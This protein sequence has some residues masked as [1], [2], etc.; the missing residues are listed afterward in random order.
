MSEGKNNQTDIW[1]GLVII[2]RV[3]LMLVIW[4]SLFLAIFLGYFTYPLFLIGLLT[5]IY[6]LSDLGIFVALKKRKRESTRSGRDEFLKSY[7]NGSGAG[8]EEYRNGV[9]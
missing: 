5:L 1:V 8:Q 9:E 7:G 4:I 3:I 6:A 2:G